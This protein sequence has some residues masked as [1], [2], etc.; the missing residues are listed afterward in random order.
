[1]KHITLHI[2]NNMVE[3]TQWKRPQKERRRKM[4]ETTNQKKLNIKS[5]LRSI[6]AKL[7]LENYQ[8]LCDLEA[9]VKELLELIQSED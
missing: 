5:K 8:H 2:K 3:Y 7:E 1:M 6:N 9:N 4:R